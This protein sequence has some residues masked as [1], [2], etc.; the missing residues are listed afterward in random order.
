[1]I[2]EFYV[3]MSIFLFTAYASSESKIGFSAFILDDELTEISKELCLQ[4][5]IFLLNEDLSFETSVKTQNGSFVIRDLKEPEVIYSISNPSYTCLDNI[6]YEDRLNTESRI[7]RYTI[8]ENGQWSAKT[9]RENA[10]YVGNNEVIIAL[11]GIDTPYT[12]SVP[13]FFD[14]STIYISKGAD[15][16]KEIKRCYE[17]GVC[18][19]GRNS[20]V[21]QWPTAFT[22][23]SVHDKIAVAID[24]SWHGYTYLYIYDMETCT[25][26]KIGEHFDICG[27]M[28]WYDEDNILAC[29][30]YGDELLLS[31]IN[32]NTAEMI[33]FTLT[34]GHQMPLEN[35]PYICMA[36]SD[37]HS[38]LAYWTEK[39]ERVFGE[40]SLTLNLLNLVSGE[41]EMLTFPECSDWSFEPYGRT[42]SQEIGDTRVFIPI[43]DYV[44][45]IFF[46]E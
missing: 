28:C 23:V 10:R 27:S 34:N 43:Y 12:L 35:A 26:S 40:N 30:K 19:E 24:D 17:T 29:R 37:D 13:D 14:K 31:L 16:Y 15:Y 42:Y 2:F 7:I 39:V 36:L 32:I 18:Y 11:D 22:A 9:F 38:M 41:R 6:S 45:S 25:V 20:A 1:M 5:R 46:M 33:P 21:W 44:P 3:L 8:D 4:Q